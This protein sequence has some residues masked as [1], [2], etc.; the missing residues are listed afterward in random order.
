ML[1]LSR[2]LIIL[3]SCAISGKPFC[4]R[5]GRQLVIQVVFRQNVQS[6]L[7]YS[8]FLRHLPL[9]AAADEDGKSEKAIN[10]ARS[11]GVS[12]WTD[13]SISP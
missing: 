8:H 4:L 2:E 13:R 12:L 3:I 6:L 9:N 10:T 7:N 1:S 11:K 5:I